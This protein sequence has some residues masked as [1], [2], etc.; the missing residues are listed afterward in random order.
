VIGLHHDISTVTGAEW[1]SSRWPSC[2]F[3]ERQKKMRQQCTA[4]Q[5]SL[6]RYCRL[7]RL[8]PTLALAKQLKFT[9]VPSPHGVRLHIYQ[10]RAL[11][12]THVRLSAPTA[13][14]FFKSFAFTHG[15]GWPF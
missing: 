12:E 8:F 5:S 14:R 6:A 10:H 11:P 2:R 4:S 9:A 13:P 7:K 15:A 1:F 3:S